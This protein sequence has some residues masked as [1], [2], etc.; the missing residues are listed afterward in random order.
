MWCGDVGG[1]VEHTRVGGR[2]CRQGG[3]APFVVVGVSMSWPTSAV[4]EGVC[5]CVA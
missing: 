1:W 2:D 5:V 4:V 3:H